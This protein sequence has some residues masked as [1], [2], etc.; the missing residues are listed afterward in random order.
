MDAQI[1]AMLPES[2]PNDIIG[3]SSRQPCQYDDKNPKGACHRC[4]LQQAHTCIGGSGAEPVLLRAI[5]VKPLKTRFTVLAGDLARFGNGQPKDWQVRLHRSQPAVSV[6]SG[7]ILAVGVFQHVG[8]DMGEWGSWPW[9]RGRRITGGGP[10]AGM[11]AIY[12]EVAIEVSD[13]V[14]RFYLLNDPGVDFEVVFRDDQANDVRCILKK[15]S[16]IEARLESNK[17]VVD[18]APVLLENASS[19]AKEFL[20]RVNAARVTMDTK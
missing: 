13:K 8:Q 2:L 17:W 15:P 14:E 1:A 7:G 16:Y 5:G 6:E 3:W 20:L 9:L 19:S 12:L 18:N 11:D 4:N 10:V